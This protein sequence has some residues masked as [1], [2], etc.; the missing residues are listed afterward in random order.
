MAIADQPPS[1][2]AQNIHDAQRVTPAKDGYTHRQPTDRIP[3][4]FT[5]FM[6]HA[7]LR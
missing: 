4:D 3:D 1:D 6:I 5:V 7:M 2:L